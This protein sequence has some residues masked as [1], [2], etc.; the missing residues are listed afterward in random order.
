MERFAHL[1][2]AICAVLQLPRLLIG[3]EQVMS[4]L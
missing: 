1:R 4:A 3:M 2:S